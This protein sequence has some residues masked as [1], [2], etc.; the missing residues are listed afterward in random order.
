MSKVLSL[1]SIYEDGD[2][3]V[4]F[5]GDAEEDVWNRTMDEHYAVDEARRIDFEIIYDNVDG[6]WRGLVVRYP[7]VT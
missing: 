1:F 4:L 5:E 6:L 2:S 7:V 3:T